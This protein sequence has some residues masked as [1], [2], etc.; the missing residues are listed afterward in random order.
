MPHRVP[1]PSNPRLHDDAG[2]ERCSTQPPCD[3]NALVL[4]GQTIGD[5]FCFVVSSRGAPAGGMGALAGRSHTPD[6]HHTCSLFGR[7]RATARCEHVTA[8]TTG[9]RRERNGQLIEESCS[10]IT[11]WGE[12]HDT[13]AALQ[14]PSWFR[15]SL[16]RSQLRIASITAQDKVGG[17]CRCWLGP[18]EALEPCVHASASHPTKE[19]RLLR[20]GAGPPE[21]VALELG[22]GASESL[23][24]KQPGSGCNRALAEK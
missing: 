5:G 9:Q 2:T 11:A 20:E 7:R 3:P 13:P 15:A 10:I 16:R 12:Q 21:C 18:L 23:C 14:Q 17:K 4:F 6:G 8:T 24:R 22:P 1:L 19:K